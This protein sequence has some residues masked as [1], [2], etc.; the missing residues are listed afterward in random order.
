MCRKVFDVLFQML[1]NLM[2]Y[3]NVVFK[4]INQTEKTVNPIN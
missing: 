1:K 4:K 2:F 3:K